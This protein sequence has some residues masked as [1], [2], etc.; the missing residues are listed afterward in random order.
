M[1]S[2]KLLF[3]P[4]CSPLQYNNG[5]AE[6]VYANV[7]DLGRHAQPYVA[8]GELVPDEIMIEMQAYSVGVCHSSLK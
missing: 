2:N 5:F 8:K 3:Y 6:H 1:S 4:Y 7:N